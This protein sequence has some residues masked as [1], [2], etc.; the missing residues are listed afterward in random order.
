MKFLHIAFR[1]QDTESVAMS[2]LTAPIAKSISEIRKTKL[3]RAA[4][5][6]AE[7]VTGSIRYR[8]SHDFR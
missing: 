6:S 8:A 5:T 1:E 3:S 2:D 7:P 4:A